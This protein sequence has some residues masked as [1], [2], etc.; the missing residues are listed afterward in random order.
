MTVIVDADA[1]VNPR[2][3]TNPPLVPSAVDEVKNLLVVLR[4]AT[5]TSLAMLTSKWLAYHTRH[6][7]VVLVEFP[8]TQ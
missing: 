5:I 7:K 3:M 1:I 8:E 2:T 4:Y 6:A